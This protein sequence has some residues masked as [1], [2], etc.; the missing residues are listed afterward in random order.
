MNKNNIIKL[1]NEVK[2]I[3]IVAATKYINYSLARDLYSY[4]ITNFGENRVDSF[5]EKFNNLTDLNITW[6][7]IGHLQKNKVKKI[8]NKIDYLHSLDS[9]DLA[10]IINEERVDVLPTFIELKLTNNDNKYG[11]KKEE[12]DDF[13]KEL[14]KYP[15]IKII[16]FMA[17]TDL[18]MTTEEKRNV[19]REARKLKEKYNLEKLSMGMTDD[20]KIAIEEGATNVRL[21]RILFDEEDMTN[22]NRV[23]ADYGIATNFKFVI[24]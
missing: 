2:P 11:I 19:F 4:G 24:K 13:I 3:P 22:F 5:L 1:I 12:L 15:K 10:K 16:G 8:I 23:L 7:F 6:H 21:G 20:Y 14:N 17:M 9:L 18:D